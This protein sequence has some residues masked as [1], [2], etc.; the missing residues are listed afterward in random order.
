MP[1]HAAVRAV[2]KI[3]PL[4][5]MALCAETQRLRR[6]DVFARRE[7]KAR[8]LPGSVA[9]GAR[10]LAV[11]KDEPA[12]KFCE[13]FRARRQ[14]ALWG[15]VVACPTRD[16]QILRVGRRRWRKSRA[17]F[18]WQHDRAK[19]RGYIEDALVNGWPWRWLRPRVGERAI[20]SG[21]EHDKGR[22]GP[23]AHVARWC[24]GRAMSSASE[25]RMA[26]PLHQR[27]LWRLHPSFFS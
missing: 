15:A 21:D 18:L 1:A 6:V 25:A 4:W 10:E 12:V 17:L 27:R 26:R 24:R 13:V 16:A 9:R 2:L 19:R 23:K 8:R 3:A 5:A 20:A 11:T 14:G 22:E 7:V